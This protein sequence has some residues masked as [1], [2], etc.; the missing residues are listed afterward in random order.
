MD[1]L[2]SFS[3]Q[4]LKNIFDHFTSL[5]IGMKSH[6]KAKE[7]DDSQYYKFKSRR[8]SIKEIFNEDVPLLSDMDV[9]GD[10]VPDNEEKIEQAFFNTLVAYTPHMPVLIS[11]RLFPLHIYVGILFYFSRE[12][13]MVLKTVWL[14]YQT[15]F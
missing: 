15:L 2:T 14:P 7:N 6:L 1:S 13:I 9:E 3:F 11:G 12:S 8:I 5:W 10:F 4:S